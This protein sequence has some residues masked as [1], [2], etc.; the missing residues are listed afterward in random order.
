MLVGTGEYP[1]HPGLHPLSCPP[2]DVD[3]LAEVLG[4]PERGDFEVTVATNW[5]L[6]RLSEALETLSVERTGDDV[7]LVYFSCHGLLDELTGELR[8]AVTNTNL[9]LLD[10]TTLHASS[11]HRLLQRSLATR[12]ILLL[13]C[14]F[15]GSYKFQ[16]LSGD[17]Y[18][19]IPAGNDLEQA[20]EDKSNDSGLSVFTEVLLDGL[21]NREYATDGWITALA[22]SRYL[23]A[24]VR[25]RSSGRQS[26]RLITNV[27]D[28][29]PLCKPPRGIVTDPAF[30]EHWRTYGRGV[31]YGAKEGFYFTG[32]VRVL[33]KIVSWLG[34]SGDSTPRVITGD[35][36]SGKSAILARI[37]TL[38][39]VTSRATCPPEVLNNAPEGTLPEPGSVDVAVRARDLS[40]EDVAKRIADALLIQGSS[41]TDVINGVMR[42]GTATV[43]IIDAVDEAADPSDLIVRLLRRLARQGAEYGVR[44]LLGTRRGTLD[45][46][47]G[48]QIIDLDEPDNIGDTDVA[49]YVTSLLLAEQ[50][51][52]SR[53]PYRANRPLAESV[54][55]AVAKRAAGNFLIAQLLALSLV[56]AGEPRQLGEIWKLPEDA[57]GALDEFLNQLAHWLS[58]TRSPAARGTVG[59]IAKWLRDLLT[60]LA[61]AEG[62][63]LSDDG[64]WAAMAGAVRPGHARFSTD[65]VAWLRASP[66]ANLL[67][68]VKTGSGTGWELFHQELIDAL[69][70]PHRES[71]GLH[72][73]IA[74]SLCDRLP[75][76]PSG[77]L[78]WSRADPY[79]RSYLAVHGERGGRLDSLLADP[80]FLIYADPDP[81]VGLLLIGSA[82][83]EAQVYTESFERHCVG[84]ALWRR[85]VLSLDGVRLGHRDLARRLANP[86]DAQPLSWQVRWTAEA[87]SGGG[88]G[89]GEYGVWRIA[90]TRLG[91]DP[92][93]ITTGSDAR[94]HV[95]DANQGELIHTLEGHTDIPY[96]LACTL[97][98]TRPVAVTGSGDLTVRVWDLIS[99][100]PLHTLE[101]HTLEVGR[102]VCAN[103]GGVPVAVSTSLDHDA[104]V[105]DLREGKLLH[106]LS[107]HTDPINAVDITSVHGQPMVITGSRDETA[108][109]WD[110]ATGELRHQL[111][112]HTGALNSVACGEY[113]GA[114]I[115]V[116]GGDDNLA[117]VWDLATGEPM[118]ELDGHTGGVNRV[119]YTTLRG[120]PIV[121]TTSEDNTARIWDPTVPRCRFVLTGFSDEVNWIRFREIEDR[122]AV[123]TSS[124]DGTVRIWDLESG[125]E[126]DILPFPA[127]AIPIEFTSDGD[128]VVAFGTEIAVLRL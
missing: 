62:T 84:D 59:E 61:I 51:P 39:D 11:V 94:V 87:H 97:L 127:P 108:G 85:K 67:R 90:C 100:T 37:A 35:P 106:V 69:G 14:C 88:G 80:E 91:L 2:R 15:G 50:D 79:T 8:F 66:V 105:W 95:W 24:E 60:P 58:K 78:D 65:D 92:V 12:K 31:L 86:T 16:D 64:V 104:V 77:A 33:Q 111:I 68:A 121:V 49:D 42:R 56:Q 4:D 107:G 44:L 99:G 117:I 18:M 28:D 73:R 43:I 1:L 119:A 118:H 30:D 34:G 23:R 7:I 9:A 116:T 22:L 63:R 125:A 3:R 25:Q 52:A 32:R 6:Q 46:L 126:L 109:I 123:F 70:K 17:G 74:D 40:T 93:V 54:A 113:D 21:A 128:L 47:P 110:L 76:H 114:S 41:P 102:V 81:L 20:W 26:P 55:Q 96:G 71:S 75:R 36:G 103:Y 122:T 112:G 89:W 115:A 83:A 48:A 10:S 124:Q 101:M 38:A 57:S 82:R 120:Q 45:E 29:I 98:G 72:G 27:P 13:D 5:P 53:T 19:V